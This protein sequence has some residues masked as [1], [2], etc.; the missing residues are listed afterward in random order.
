MPSLVDLL[1]V[2]LLLEAALGGLEVAVF[3]GDELAG[4][5]LVSGDVLT[6]QSSTVLSSPGSG[7]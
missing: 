1:P 4:Q 5:L 3:L 7:T 6:D 2:R